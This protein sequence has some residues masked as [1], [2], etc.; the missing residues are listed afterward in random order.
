MVDVD[1]RLERAIDALLADRRAGATICPSEAARAVDPEGWRE[2]MP[3][4]RAAAGRLAAAGQVE[5]TQ[6]GEVVD[7]AT[8]RGPV[9]VRRVAGS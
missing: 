5:V 7:V 6:R 4:A 2:L 8:A 1:G 3:A 9:R